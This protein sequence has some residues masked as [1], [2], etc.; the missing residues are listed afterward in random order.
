MPRWHGREYD[1]SADG[2]ISLDTWFQK[3]NW[4]VIVSD[5]LVPFRDN[6]TFVKIMRYIMLHAQPLAYPS[7]WCSMIIHGLRDPTS[8]TQ[9]GYEII[10]EILWN[11]YATLKIK[12]NYQIKRLFST[13][14]DS[15]CYVQ[16][17]D[18]IESLKSK[19]VQ[20]AFSWHFN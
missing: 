11:I 10:I 7:K 14:H 6:G 13:R 17:C 12:H 9:M 5:V 16:V 4:I 1:G 19:S 3:I 8:I 20:A 18:L 2:E 15:W